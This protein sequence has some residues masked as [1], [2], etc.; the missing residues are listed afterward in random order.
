MPGWATVYEAIDLGGELTAR[1][2]VA[3]SCFLS[4]D[5]GSMCAR[6]PKEGEG[7]SG[8]RNIMSCVGQLAPSPPPEATGKV[9]AAVYACL[10]RRTAMVPGDLDLSLPLPLS[11]SRRLTLSTSLGKVM[12]AMFPGIWVWVPQQRRVISGRVSLLFHG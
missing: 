12:T 2:V 11:L 10:I 4:L 1:G 8:T 3:P 5:D 6:P 7:S 9:P